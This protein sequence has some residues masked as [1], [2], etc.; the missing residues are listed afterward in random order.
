MRRAKPAS[1]RICASRMAPCRLTPRAS[2]RAGIGCGVIRTGH[3]MAGFWRSAAA[4]AVV[5]AAAAAAPV[6][7]EGAKVQMIFD[8]MAELKPLIGH[9][10]ATI[11]YHSRDGSVS[12]E[13][14]DYSVA[15]VLD[16]TYLQWSVTVYRPDA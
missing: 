16:G 13:A 4:G 11:D 1:S 9:W 7:A 5:L 3:R 12:R 8:H 15:P 6:H 2:R 14:A 10:T